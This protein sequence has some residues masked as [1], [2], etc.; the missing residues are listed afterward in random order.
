MYTKSE[1]NTEKCAYNGM[2]LQIYVLS[3]IYSYIAL[4]HSYIMQDCEWKKEL[5]KHVI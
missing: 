3:H 4:S 5:G 2:Y 1:V